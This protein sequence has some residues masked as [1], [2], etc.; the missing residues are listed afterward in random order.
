MFQKVWLQYES[1]SKVKTQ[2]NYTTKHNKITTKHNKITTKHNK[3][4]NLNKLTK[5]NT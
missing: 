3:I 5:L 1:T 2:Q 4:T